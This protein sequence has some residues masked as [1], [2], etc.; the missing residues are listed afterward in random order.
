[1]IFGFRRSARTTAAIA[2]LGMT[3]V[4]AGTVL[5]LVA[6]GFGIERGDMRVDA[7]TDGFANRLYHAAYVAL[8]LSLAAQLAGSVVL[9]GMGLPFWPRA[10]WAF[11]LAALFV[12]TVLCSYAGALLL[13]N[14]GS[15]CLP[16]RDLCDAL[17][18]LILKMT[19]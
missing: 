9:L 15:Y 3:L 16:L 8:A 12:A 6:V 1:V 5:L 13:L 10:H 18:N 7:E 2:A 4:A 14:Y 11:R 17:S 19:P